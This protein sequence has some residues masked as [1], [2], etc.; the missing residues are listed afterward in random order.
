MAAVEW[1][2]ES[3][4]YVGVIPPIKANRRAGMTMHHRD[5]WRAGEVEADDHER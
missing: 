4:G 5:R 3:E 2:T 1:M